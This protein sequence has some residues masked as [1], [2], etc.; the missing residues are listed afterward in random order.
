MP[1]FYCPRHERLC[2]PHGQTWVTWPALYVAMLPPFCT[3]LDAAKIDASRYT[4]I[5]TPC[6]R[7]TAMARQAVEEHIDPL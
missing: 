6:D 1:L 2:D 7:C 4:V 5:P 3:L